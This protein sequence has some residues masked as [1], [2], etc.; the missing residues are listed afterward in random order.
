MIKSRLV[1]YASQIKKPNNQAII[2]K[3]SFVYLC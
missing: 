2:P 3:G 1:I